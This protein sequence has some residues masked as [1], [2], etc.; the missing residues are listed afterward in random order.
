MQLPASSML[1]TAVM[2]LLVF[3]MA[4]IEKDWLAFGHPFA[5]RLGMPT[6]NSSNNLYISDSV[7]QSSGQNISSPVRLS[8]GSAFTSSLSHTAAASSNNFSPI[9]LQWVD[10]VSQLLRLYPRAFEFSSAF[11]VEILDCVF[12]CRFGNFLC[13]SEKERFQAGISESCGCMWVYL[14][15]QRHARG[16]DHEHFN[17]FYDREHQDGSLLPPA[18]A[19]APM[20]WPN[21]FLRWACPSEIH[22]GESSCSWVQGG[23]LENQCRTLVQSYTGFKKAKERADIKVRELSSRLKLMSEELRAEKQASLSTT[24]AL[25]R[26]EKENNAIKRALQAIGCK[27]RF[28]ESGAVLSSSE[29][30]E[31]SN[32]E[33]RR[34]AHGTNFLGANIEDL[35]VS[36]SVA[37]DTDLSAEFLRRPCGDT[38]DS[39]NEE[40]CRWPASGCARLGSGFAGIRANFGAL[41]NLSIDDSYFEVGGDLKRQPYAPREIT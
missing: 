25:A 5:D 18:A 33:G 10:C 23:E 30:E 24:A 21:Y 31:T 4:L 2:Y 20:L 38:C 14:E 9:F 29:D 40:G 39:E 37:P 11:L 3:G 28:S 34:S 17:I 13:N 8:Q 19:L 6:Y 7:R 35:A 41:E 16:K 22:A 32:P 36:V 12:S 26:I 27:V 15:K 1:E